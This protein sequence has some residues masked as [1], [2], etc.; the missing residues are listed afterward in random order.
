MYSL[1]D[2]LYPTNGP[3]DTL[4]CWKKE[5]PRAKAKPIKEVRVAKAGN[6]VTKQGFKTRE[7]TARKLKSSGVKRSHEEHK[8]KR[9]R[10]PIQERID[11]ALMYFCTS[12]R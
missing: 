1:H 4:C 9:S 2:C 6:L 8:S 10:S 3:T 11:L 12:H 5:S 7:E